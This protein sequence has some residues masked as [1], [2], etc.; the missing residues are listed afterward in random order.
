MDPEPRVTD[1]SA[2]RDGVR[3]RFPVG[4]DLEGRSPEAAGDFEVAEEID[5][6]ETVGDHCAELT[7]SDWL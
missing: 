4:Q 5:P 2:E 3:Q 6:G 1:Q 7:A